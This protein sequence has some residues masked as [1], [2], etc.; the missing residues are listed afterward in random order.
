MVGGW[1]LGYKYKGLKVGRKLLDQ[2]YRRRTGLLPINQVVI[3]WGNSGKMEESRSKSIWLVKQKKVL[4]FRNT[5][6]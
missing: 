5:F 1:G 4:P 3:F 6:L 2:F